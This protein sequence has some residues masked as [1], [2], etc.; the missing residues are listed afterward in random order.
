MPTRTID[1]EK[2]LCCPE[3]ALDLARTLA[4]IADLVHPALAEHHRITS[5]VAGRIGEE[6]GLSQESLHNLKLAAMVHDIGALTLSERIASLT[7]DFEDDEHAIPGSILLND[8]A[9]FGVAANIVRYHHTQWEHGAGTHDSLGNEIPLESRLVFLADR[10]AVAA[11][12]AGEPLGK[13]DAVRNIITPMSGEYF[14]LEAVDAFNAVAVEEAFWFDIEYI[15]Q[16]REPMMKATINYDEIESGPVTFTPE[17]FERFA[18]SAAQIIDF[19]SHFTSTHSAGVA[20][21]AEALGRKLGC[22]EETAYKLRVGGLLHD[23]GKLAVPAEILEKNGSL[24]PTERNVIEAHA[25][26]SLR[27]LEGL[28]K[29]QDL[30]FAA[31]HHEKLSGSGY[32]LHLEGTLLSYKAR[33][34]AIADVFTALSEDRPYRKGLGRE[35]ID[36]MQSMIE[37]KHLDGEIAS[38]LFESIDEL[39]VIRQSAQDRAHD[40]FTHFTRNCRECAYPAASA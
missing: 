12:G 13:G 26:F 10:I 27:V 36:I 21:V 1:S 7:L 18:R 17:S 40:E 6:L 25:Y 35:S 28:A 37:G 39:N 8:Y 30:T 16:G 34:M 11:A 23:V 2:I 20:A 15:K 38:A 9:P 19:K 33:I 3:V 14:W 5:Y 31:H 29:Y 22:D 24:T 4:S 32:P